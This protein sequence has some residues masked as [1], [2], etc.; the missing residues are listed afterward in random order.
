MPMQQKENIYLDLETF[1]YPVIIVHDQYSQVVNVQIQYK[2][3][4]IHEPA[5]L[6]GITNLVMRLS[7]KRT[8]SFA[9]DDALMQAVE[10]VG[11]KL[12]SASHSE[13]HWVV[14]QMSNSQHM[15]QGLKLL[16]EVVWQPLFTDELLKRE[17]AILQQDIMH[18]QDDPSNW[19][20]T[21]GLSKMWP[22]SLMGKPVIGTAESIERITVDDLKEHHQKM[23]R[24]PVVIGLSGPITPKEFIAQLASANIIPA[25]GAIDAVGTVGDTIFNSTVGPVWAVE[26]R[27]IE[28]L[29][30]RMYFPAPSLVEADYMAQSLFTYAFG[31]GFL[32]RLND[33]IRNKRSLAYYYGNSYSNS[34]RVGIYSIRGGVAAD[35][36]TDVFKATWEEVHDVQQNGL[37]S[38]EIERGFNFVTGY[39]SRNIELSDEYL[40]FVLKQYDRS[41]TIVTFDEWKGLLKEVDHE[42]IKRVAQAVLQPERVIVGVVGPVTL[43]QVQKAW[44]G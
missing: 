11:A 21:L 18:M 44:A 29:N 25:K 23:R 34:P 19:A 10:T 33:A 41:G 31:V 17:R 40:G 1:G 26:D 38:D 6:H 20:A 3:G 24:V 14:L 5:H 4:A 39:F 42:D 36:L 37:S 32:S 8:K 43:A 2:L 9:S 22:G 7:E 30:L 15:A 12:W 16:K 27:H 28:Q 35:K 13:Q